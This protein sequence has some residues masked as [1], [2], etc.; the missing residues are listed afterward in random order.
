M[1]SER[2][3]AGRKVLIYFTEGTYADSLGQE[4]TQSIIGA[5]NRANISIYCI[6]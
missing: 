2:G 6:D 5:A 1:G 4:M 3:L